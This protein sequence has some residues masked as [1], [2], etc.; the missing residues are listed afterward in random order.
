MLATILGSTFAPPGVPKYQIP[1]PGD[2]PVESRDA[3]D[4]HLIYILVGCDFAIHSH[5]YKLKK[6]QGGGLASGGGC[7][8]AL[9]PVFTCGNK[10]LAEGE[11]EWE[12]ARHRACI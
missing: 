8:A 4:L 1:L 12:L 7:S 2:A 3:L 10:R 9:R 11:E 5:Y 6:P